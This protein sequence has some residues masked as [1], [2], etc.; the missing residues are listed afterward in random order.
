MRV[1]ESSKSVLDCSLSSPLL[2]E[3][4][5]ERPRERE[6]ETVKRER[7]RPVRLVWLSAASLIRRKKEEGSE[8]VERSIVCVCGC[9]RFCFCSNSSTCSVL[10]TDRERQT[11][12]EE[13][14]QGIDHAHT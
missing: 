9:F 5:R 14:S 3:R 4:T 2:K 11:D 10:E 7:E 6:R 8:Q 1:R 13:A 12:R